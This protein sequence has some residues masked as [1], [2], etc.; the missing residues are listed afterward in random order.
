[1]ERRRDQ[2]ASPQVL[3]RLEH[4]Q[5]AI[6]KPSEQDVVAVPQAQRIP[7]EQPADSAAISCEHAPRQPPEVQ[8]EGVAVARV[9]QLAQLL[10]APD[11]QDRLDHW[12]QA[13]PGRKRA[14]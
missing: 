10:I 2:F 12:R 13:R 4:H 7:R 3:S 11:P 9:A 6:A 14:S 1:V 8:R 5:R